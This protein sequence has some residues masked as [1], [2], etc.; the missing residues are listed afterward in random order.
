MRVRLFGALDAPID[1]VPELQALRPRARTPSSRL[2]S[3]IAITTSGVDF[4]SGAKVC[5]SVGSSDCVSLI[6]LR[7]VYCSALPWSQTICAARTG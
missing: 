5:T 2:G 1:A 3:A 4:R 6:R 7:S